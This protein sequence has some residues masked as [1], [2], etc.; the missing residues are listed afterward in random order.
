[1]NENDILNGFISAPSNDQI[2]RPWT[3]F[4]NKVIATNRLTILYADVAALENRYDK[5]PSVFQPEPFTPF[6]FNTLSDDKYLPVGDGFYSLIEGESPLAERIDGVDKP[7]ITPVE[8]NYA[9]NPIMFDLW[10]MAPIYN[11]CLF[12]DKGF[13]MAHSRKDNCLMFK[14]VSKGIEMAI[15]LLEK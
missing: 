9:G 3:N 8:T 6:M 14:H 5:W 12:W 11:A 13:Y 2:A 15:K 7:V 10:Q 1:M 4:E